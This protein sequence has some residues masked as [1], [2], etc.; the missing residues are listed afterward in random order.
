MQLVYRLILSA[1]RHQRFAS[2]TEWNERIRRL[3]GHLNDKSSTSAG[4]RLVAVPLRRPS[5]QHG[6]AR[7]DSCSTPPFAD[8]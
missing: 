8:T 5:Q 4:N 3:P 6:F 1:L 7:P 2:L